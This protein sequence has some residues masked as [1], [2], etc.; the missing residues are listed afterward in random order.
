M[1]RTYRI[2]KRFKDNHSSGSSKIQTQRSTLQ[3]TKKDPAV[4]IISQ[5]SK[6][7]LTEIIPHLAVVPG[8]LE[9]FL[10]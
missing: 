5:L 7:S 1:N 3:T 8:E 4:G 6:A 10:A 2:P 9:P